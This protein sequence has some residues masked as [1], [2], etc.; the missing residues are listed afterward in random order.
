MHTSKRIL[1]SMLSAVMAAGSVV[2][3]NAAAAAEP[4][5]VIGEYGAV[6]ETE[7]SDEPAIIYDNEGK[8]VNVVMP[9]TADEGVYEAP[10]LMDNGEV[11]EW[12]TTFNYNSKTGILMAEAYPFEYNDEDFEPS[13]WRLYGYYSFYVNAGE[14]TYC[15]SSNSLS[16][17]GSP[18]PSVNLRTYLGKLYMMDGDFKD[19]VD[20]GGKVTVY[21]K[22]GSYENWEATCIATSNEYVCDFTGWNKR[23]SISAPSVVYN[24]NDDDI[25]INGVKGAT[26]Y[27]YSFD[28]EDLY[29]TNDIIINTISDTSSELT[30]C[31]V[32]E[33]GVPGEFATITPVDLSKEYDANVS[34]SKR[35]GLYGFDDIDVELPNESFELGDYTI[36]ASNDNGTEVSFY[37][38]KAS[39]G[40][41]Y[42][43]KSAVML[44]LAEDSFSSA[45]NSSQ[46][47]EC[48]VKYEG[49]D[50]IFRIGGSKNIRSYYGISA[51]DYNDYPIAKSVYQD[52]EPY[53]TYDGA[54]FDDNTPAP[55]NFRRSDNSDFVVTW[56][57]ASDDCIGY[58]VIERITD[59]NG[60]TYVHISSTDANKL[61][62]YRSEYGYTTN[63]T[64]NAVNSNGDLSSVYLEGTI[65]N[66]KGGKEYIDAPT[67]WKSNIAFDE[68][69]NIVS[70]DGYPDTDEMTEMYT[71]YGVSYSLTS[72][73]DR[74]FGYNRNTD[75]GQEIDL[76][77][78]FVQKY[79]SSAPFYGKNEAKAFEYHGAAYNA[80]G[81]Y[82]VSEDSTVISYYGPKSVGKIKAPENMKYTLSGFESYLDYFDEDRRDFETVYFDQIDGAQSYILKLITKFGIKY[83]YSVNPKI[84]FYSY[85]GDFDVSMAYVDTEGNVS[86]FSEPVSFS[87]DPDVL[88]GVSK[89][90][91]LTVNSDNSVSLKWTAAKNASGYM[92]K[93]YNADN[94][95]TV[96]NYIN[97]TGTS[98]TFNSFQPGTYTA[99]VVALDMNENYSDSIY[100]YDDTVFTV[101]GEKVPEPVTPKISVE[102][103]DGNAVITWAAVEGAE[104]YRIFSVI[105]GRY[106]LLGEIKDTE[107]LADGLTNGQKTGFLVLSKVNGEW[108]TYTS[109]DIVYVTPKS[110]KSDKPV[111]TAEPTYGGAEVTWGEVEGAVN[112]RVY[113]FVA[114]G[115]IRQFGSDTTETSMT[116]K[117]L[118]GGEKTG[119]I[120]LA[121]YAN[122]KWTKYTDDDIAYVIPL[123]A[124][125]P[126]LC[127]NPKGNGSYYLIWSS[128]PTSVRYKV[129]AREKG[130]NNWELIGATR[131]RCRVT[132]QLDPN[133]EYEFLV[134]G[135]NAKNK[136]TPMDADDI[137]SG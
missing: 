49:D 1:T 96:Y 97:S 2:L 23:S 48:G 61:K 110:A 136:Y 132:V 58:I 128:V 27:Y 65:D 125:K 55:T 32:D 133:K 101:E 40:R 106:N 116:V 107:Y 119:I 95:N 83:N 94:D 34:Y 28:G 89:I 21:V 18:T 8:A 69:T 115:K 13:S 17:W 74:W 26:G 35:T 131:Q 86:A 9:Q 63:I 14:N 82:P 105:N 81:T 20:N 100:D 42:V 109:R 126:Y 78:T 4:D 117:G 108:S 25:I 39:D 104:S 118:K 62:L 80:I 114:G 124:V 44:S 59:K 98:Y 111:V 16:A 12:Q 50:Q 137:V 64:I 103:G 37:S 67:T 33:A 3:P 43:P 68:K 112:Y 123:D 70:F 77:D 22:V 73:T 11:A 99:T 19:Y 102:A 79:F 66:S 60:N 129:M 52:D 53:I 85:Y 47:Y 75:G 6:R 127:V 7:K 41:Y 30:I 122:G 113:T 24:I 51:Y 93:I 56:D 15:I 84:D 36:T 87:Y 130:T 120:V 46:K 57:K 72:P 134:R 88:V 135:L 10:E 92:I 5:V 45:R 38:E 71:E 31:S 76:T 91:S 29:F 121:Q 90:T 54:D